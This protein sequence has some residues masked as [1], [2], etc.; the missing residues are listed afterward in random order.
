MVTYVAKVGAW[1]AAVASMA[2]KDGSATPS[3]ASPIAAANPSRRRSV[4]DDIGLKSPLGHSF[5]AC[6]S[7]SAGD[8]AIEPW[9]RTQSGVAMSDGGGAH[10]TG[11]GVDS[12]ARRPAR[13]ED[14]STQTEDDDS[15]WLGDVCCGGG[16]DAKFRFRERRS[17]LHKSMS[18]LEHKGILPPARPTRNSEPFTQSA[19]AVLTGAHDLQTFRDTR[20]GAALLS[21]ATGEEQVSLIFSFG[22]EVARLVADVVEAQRQAEEAAAWVGGLFCEDQ[23]RRAIADEAL[24]KAEWRRSEAEQRL[25]GALQRAEEAES[26]AAQLEEADARALL[27]TARV[28][29]LERKEEEATAAVTAALKPKLEDV[30]MTKALQAAEEKAA[31][32]AERAN[33]AERRCEELMV[34]VDVL[35]R[36]AVE[37][38]L[39]DNYVQAVA[40]ERAKVLEKDKADLEVRLA[41]A[42]C[43]AAT[44]EAQVGTGNTRVRDLER[45]CVE[46]LARAEAAER[47]Q[48][49]GSTVVV[50]P[51]QEACG[52]WSGQDEAL[53]D[54]LQRIR[55]F[56]VERTSAALLL[57]DL[58]RRCDEAAAALASSCSELARTQALLR[59]E[60]RLSEQLRCV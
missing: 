21:S 2:A 5:D 38:Q 42:L 51:Q 11:G 17:I 14:A 57:E 46:L 1:E 45:R 8:G 10:S 32:S 24:A 41:D 49:Q 36:E 25:A 56:E 31:A 52:G 53:R 47:A 30:S 18:N 58:S 44:A 43:R 34:R 9:D 19:R 15:Q 50:S 27:L 39:D 6:D 16:V 28:S 48:S 29:E 13:L 4:P 22:A 54:A 55:I 37:R 59:C 20:P 35:E 23:T 12:P 3:C 33:A 40:A 7:E 26:R 60:Q